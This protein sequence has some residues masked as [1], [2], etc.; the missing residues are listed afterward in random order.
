MSR[1]QDSSWS[2]TLAKS[3][4]Q[5]ILNGLTDLG[6]AFKQSLQVIQDEVS[7]VRMD[8]RRYRS[9]E[10]TF[11]SW[12]WNST[13]RAGQSSSCHGGQVAGGL[14]ELKLHISHGETI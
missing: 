11:E 9:C 2:G 1:L 13:N 5:T 3:I 7:P 12:V 6:E 14:T 4:I 8:P 10:A